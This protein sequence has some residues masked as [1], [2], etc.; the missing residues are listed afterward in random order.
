MKAQHVAVALLLVSLSLAPAQTVL[1][2]F[3]Q[4]AALV[5]DEARAVYLGNLARAQQGVPPLRWNRQLTQAARW[6]AWD[7]V[8][9][10]PT[11][12]C[13]HTD[14]KGHNAD[15]R[16][17]AFGYPGFA[18]AENAYCSY[19]TPEQAIADWMASPPHRANLLDPNSREV[20][21]G[22]YLRQSDS[23]GYVVQDFGHDPAYPPVIIENEAITT[24]STTV[25][26]YIYNREP[27]GGFAGIGPAVQ[28]M[29]AHGPCFA[30]AAWQAYTAHQAWSLEGGQGWRDVYVKTRDVLSRSVVVS[31]TI[32]LGDNVPLEELGLAQT[33]TT[34][35][36]VTLYE[37]DGGGLPSVQLSLGWQADDIFDTFKLWWGNGERVSD[38]AAWGGSAFRLRPGSG[39]SFAWVWTTDFFKGSPMVAYF[40]LK[41]SDNTSG[42][43]V[44]RVSV[45]GGGIEYGP[46]H[47]KGTDFAQ[48]N[49]YQ[50][51]ALPFTFH[52]SPDDPFL[53]FNFWRSGSADVVVDVVTIFTASQPASSP[54]TWS[55]PGGNYRGQGVWVRYADAG[56]IF[57]PIHEASLA[58]AQLSV[59]PRALTI[60]AALN[61]PPPPPRRL[62]V[63]MG[64]GSAGWTASDDADWLHWQIDHEDLL[65]SVDYDGLTVGRY[66]ATLTLEPVGG[67]DLQP[68][69]VLVTLVVVE[70]L[71]RDYL[72]LIWRNG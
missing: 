57:S 47:L 45:K 6:F 72:P 16:A 71:Q 15:W 61:E 60:L 55:V 23:R 49:H 62:A 1:G 64:C 54:L 14:T 37:L 36:Q 12:Y 42:S 53:I 58:P 40:R 31:D 35:P 65:V 33:S 2:Q 63:R 32:Y 51:F 22:Y 67:Q 41:V 10:R 43:E 9:N 69:T 21:L 8:E 68:V 28:M 39:E 24:T 30:D 34:Q 38:P 11:P 56:G 20:G 18:G 5:Y 52:A 3:S 59:A 66:L 4:S 26:L 27:R 50:E 44:A 46:L 70:Q 19:M 17:A 13:G 25:G 29:L 7:S 48:A